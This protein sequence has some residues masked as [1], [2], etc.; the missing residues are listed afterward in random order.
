M[1]AGYFMVS[2]DGDNLDI[3]YQVAKGATGSCPDDQLVL[4]NDLE[5][6]E[7]ALKVLYPDPQARLPRF[8]ELLSLAQVGLQGDA[9][10]KVAASALINLKHSILTTEGSARKNRY[11]KELG[12]L[13]AGFAGPLLALAALL[14][15][16]F[17]QLPPILDPTFVTLVITFALL[18]AGSMIGAWL[19]YGLRTETLTFDDLTTP[20]EDRLDPGVRLVFVGVLTLVVALA[21]YLG[22]V[23]ISLGKI[24]SH[25]VVHRN[26]LAL[27]V[28]V[29][30]GASERA[31]TGQ[32][33]KLVSNLLP[34][35]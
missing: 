10:P 26:S 5:S 21:L 11:L 34:S 33:I 31:L 6:T 18:L 32:V 1:A 29:L 17:P 4:K 8:R 30:L 24:S 7:A 3:L 12:K 13:A 27:L 25:D 16:G 22:V 9:E 35:K 28:G 19:S 2:Q 23:E 15:Y 20:E 14:K